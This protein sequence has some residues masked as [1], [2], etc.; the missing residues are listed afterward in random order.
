MTLP[1]L[2]LAVATSTGACALPADATWSDA[3]DLY[4]I[5]REASIRWEGTAE[6]RGAALAR[7]EADRDDRGRALAACH[8]RLVEA[9][10]PPAEVVSPWVVGV[11]AGV[12]GAAIGVLVGALAL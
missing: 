9:P 8:T 10:P 2:I 12:A 1:A 6:A 5:E 4:C 3:S 11:A 7:C